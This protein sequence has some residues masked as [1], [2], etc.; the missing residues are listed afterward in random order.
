MI[1][2]LSECD[3]FVGMKLHSQILAICAGVPTLA[4]EYQPKTVDFM[5][6][7]GGESETVRLDGLNAVLLRELV[8]GLASAREEIATRQ[9]RGCR[10]LAATFARYVSDIGGSA[11]GIDCYVAGRRPT[12]GSIRSGSAGR[13][14][15]E[16]WPSGK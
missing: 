9:W 3:V 13:G 11:E 4:I 15:G 6:S 2:A 14:G 12:T 8:G 1:E 16:G 7:I 10:A 5:S